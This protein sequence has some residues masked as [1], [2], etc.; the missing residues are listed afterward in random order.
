MRPWFLLLVAAVA[1][2]GCASAAELA[3][4]DDNTCRGYGFIAGTDQ[5]AQCRERQ[6]IARKQADA[7]ALANLSNA[8]AA[9]NSAIANAPS[10]P[11]QQSLNCTT[12]SM[13]AGTTHTTCY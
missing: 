12:R 13:G 4:A 9:A 11:P 10:P 7:E 8:I 6:D 3:A 5:Y 2:G 1:L